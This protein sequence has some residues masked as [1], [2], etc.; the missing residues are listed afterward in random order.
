M[1][2]MWNMKRKEKG[3][4]KTK[5]SRAKNWNEEGEN[6]AETSQQESSAI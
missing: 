5:E 2:I 6:C 3:E 1:S 4:E